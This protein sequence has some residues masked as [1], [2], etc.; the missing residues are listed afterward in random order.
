MGN[1]CIPLQKK[2]EKI[3]NRAELKSAAK[4]QIR[5]KIGILFVISLVMGLVSSAVSII[6]VVGTLVVVPAF[7]LSM[8]CIYLNITKGQHPTVGD[9]FSGFSDFW[10]YCLHP[11]GR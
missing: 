8:T 2:E 11:S 6:P 9:A 7:A 4:E 1:I 10:S 5:G 3:M